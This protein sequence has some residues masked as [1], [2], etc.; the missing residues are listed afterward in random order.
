MLQRAVE[1]DGDWHRGVTR[2]VRY[3][4]LFIYHRNIEMLTWQNSNPYL[5]R[6][7]LSFV[8]PSNSLVLVFKP[9][10]GFFTLHNARQKQLKQTETMC[11]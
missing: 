11:F 9:L 1:L 10:K 7:L 8:P 4:N 2:S 5:G 6:T 3:P